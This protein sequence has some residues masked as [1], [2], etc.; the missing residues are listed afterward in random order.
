MVNG[1][2]VSMT[3][4]CGTKRNPYNPKHPGGLIYD[5]ETICTQVI[6]NDNTTQ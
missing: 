5:Q 3:I 1:T 6:E 2:I 4:G